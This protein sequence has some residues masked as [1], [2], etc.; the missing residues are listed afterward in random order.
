ME[1][2]FGRCEVVSNLSNPLRKIYQSLDRNVEALF[3][4]LCTFCSRFNT[5]RSLMR[6]FVYS[7][8]GDLMLL[9]TKGPLPSGQEEIKLGASS[10][11]VSLFIS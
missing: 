7:F 11:K 4:N 9:R 6:S 5:I 1:H 3:C 10:P 2:F 8:P